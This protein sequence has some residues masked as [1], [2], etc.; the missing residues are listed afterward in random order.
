M[1]TGRSSDPGAVISLQGDVNPTWLKLER[2]SNAFS[3]YYSKD[4]INWNLAGTISYNA[5]ESV[6]LGLGAIN[7]NLD[8]NFAAM[9]D[10][11][12]LK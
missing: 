12:S 8:S 3:G 1:H 7:V 10:Y 4:G 2:K 5:P 11:I 9:F 6:Q